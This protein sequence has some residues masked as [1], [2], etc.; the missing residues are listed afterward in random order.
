ML[1]AEYLYAISIGN[2]PLAIV[3]SLL[4]W[5]L[6]YQGY[7]AVYPSFFPELFPP[8]SRVSGMAIAGNF[9]IFLTAM[10]PALFAWVSP[11]HSANIPIKVASICFGLCFLVA[12]SAW[13]G[14]ETYRLRVEDLGNPNAVP[15]PKEEYER[16]RAKSIADAV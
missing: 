14:R 7:N 9:G 1:L 16:L 15:L 6:V 10:L 5:G 4:M 11:P 2:V 8:R 12:V 13:S 3:L